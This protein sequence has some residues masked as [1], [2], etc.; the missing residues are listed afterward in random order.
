MATELPRLEIVKPITYVP[1]DSALEEA[2]ARMGIALPPSYVAFSKR[3]GFGL[4]C[5]L[6]IIYVPVPKPPPYGDLVAYSADL[7]RELED[8]MAA[9][10]MRYEPDGSEDLIRRAVPFGGS[11]NG[12]ILFWDSQEK[13]AGDE[14]PIYVVGARKSG[15]MRAAHDLGE[16]LTKALQPN[17][18]GVLGRATFTLDPTFEPLD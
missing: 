3:Y 7:R 15:V 2:G 13:L 10:R 18:G 12:N 14:Y 5:G 4:T 1:A 9:G 8:S 17:L 6:F 16:F 11:E